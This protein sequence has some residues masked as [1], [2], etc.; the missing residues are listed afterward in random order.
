MKHVVQV[1]LFRA[2]QKK[3]KGFFYLDTHAGRGSYDLVAAAGDSLA[4]TPEW[5]DG[6]GRLGGL[7][8][9]LPAPVAEYVSLVRAFDRQHGNLAGAIR[10]YPGSPAIARMLRRDDDRLAF[11]EQ[12]PDEY[13]A[14]QREFAADRRISLHPTDGYAAVRAMLPPPERRTLVLIDPPFEAPD[15][16]QRMV[17]AVGEGLARHP[18]AVFALWYPLTERARVGDFLDRLRA[19]R[20]PPTLRLELTI[21]GQQVPQK[22]KG[23]GLIVINPPW[24]FEAEAESV[25][26]ALSTVLAQAPG[27]GRWIEWL[28]P[29]R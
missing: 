16:F 25:L 1:Q 18:A 2:L 15:E 7:G 19:L 29:E 10:F 27:G 14:L 23:S 12:H 11:C 13:A 4:R 6:I 21:A 26:R 20:L 17:G 9:S 5:P 24:Q 22:M 3:E 28:V 8:D